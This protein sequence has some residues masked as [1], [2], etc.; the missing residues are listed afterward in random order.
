MFVVLFGRTATVEL[1]TATICF[2]VH[3]DSSPIAYRF[4][5]ASLSPQRLPS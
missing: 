2:L 3:Y 5:H 4:V 1:F